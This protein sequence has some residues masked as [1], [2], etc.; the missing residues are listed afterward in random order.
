MTDDAPGAPRA[1]QE[2]PQGGHAADRLREQL[3]RDL[4]AVPSGRAP[5]SLDEAGAD[6]PGP[7]TDGEDNSNRGGSP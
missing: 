1:D 3:I 6:P 7:D 4:G 2:Q 5:G